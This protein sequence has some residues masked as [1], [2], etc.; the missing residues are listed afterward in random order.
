MNGIVIDI[1]PVIAHIGG[2][3]LRWYGLA[4]ALAV[5]AAVW[6]AV[7]EGKRRGV[8]PDD[9]YSIVSWALVGGLVGAR[10]FHIIDQWEYY[11]ANPSQ[12]VQFQQGGLAIWGG[13]AGGSLATLLYA[14]IKRLPIARLTD[15]AAPA[16][17]V[18]QMVGR[19]GCIINGDAYGGATNLPW[20]FIYQNPKSLIPSQ[21]LGVPTHPYPVYEILWDAVVL[22]VILRLGRRWQTSGLVFASYLALYSL[23]RMLLTFVRQETIVV[24]G[25]QQAQIL[26]LITLLGAVALFFH[27]WSVLPKGSEKSVS[28]NR[29]D[30]TLEPEIES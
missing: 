30:G 6:M 21:L 15:V 10:L 16:L 4:I 22:F 19:L 12:L 26:A 7:R 1:D 23:G 13:L 28:T 5:M 14:R 20:G 2:F 3:E 9:I 18:G 24:A 25:L 11:S 17:L 27:L 29:P 8:S